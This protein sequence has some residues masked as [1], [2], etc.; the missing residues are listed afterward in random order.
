MYHP[1]PGVVYK[2]ATR[3]AYLPETAESCALLKRLK[4]AFQHGLTFSVGTSLTS[5]QDNSVIWKSIPHKT[6]LA[7]GA[8]RYGYPDSNYIADCHNELDKLN[9]P[10]AD[11]L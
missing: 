1:N 3:R 7:G 4:F 11:V 6:S 2:G 10:S 5:G 9:V 8:S